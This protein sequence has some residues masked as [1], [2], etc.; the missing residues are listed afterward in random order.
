M[1]VFSR[2]DGNYNDKEFGFEGAGIPIIIHTEQ[3]SGKKDNT[4]ATEKRIDLYDNAAT[5]VMQ[6]ARK[7]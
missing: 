1:V 3:K 2:G 7:F 6:A 5:N 4:T